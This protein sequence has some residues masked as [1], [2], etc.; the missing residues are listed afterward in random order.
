MPVDAAI[1][2]SQSSM[3]VRSAPIRGLGA[4]GQRSSVV[5]PVAET[6]INVSLTRSDNETSDALANE[7][8]AGTAAT[9]GSLPMTIER[10]ERCRGGMVC[11]APVVA[12]SERW[13]RR[14]DRRHGIVD[15][16]NCRT[17]G[18]GERRA[19]AG[20]C[21][22]MR[23]A[24]DELHGR[25]R[26]S[27]ASARESAGCERW[28]LCAARVMLPSSTIARK[29]RRW[30]SST[31]IRHEHQRIS[32]DLRVVVVFGLV[33]AAMNVCFYVAVA[34]L[35]LGIAVTIELFGPLGLAAA[36]SRTAREWGYVALAVV[37]VVLL[38][39]ATHHLDRIGVAY[40]LAAA[41]GWASYILLSRRTGRSF[42]GVDGLALTMV[43]ATVA[44]APFGIATG[45]ARLIQT[46]SARDRIR[47]GDAVGS[48]PVQP[49]AP[50][51]ARCRATYVRC[52]HDQQPG[53]RRGYGL[54]CA[55]RVAR[56]TASDG[57]C[58]RNSR[59]RRHGSG[60][61]CQHLGRVRCPLLDYDLGVRVRK[62]EAHDVARR[63]TV[64]QCRHR[65]E[66]AAELDR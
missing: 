61:R 42:D 44:V 24:I 39:G 51:T 27:R 22:V 12:K 16:S 41:I 66:V 3:F 26:S 33:L 64:G 43:V 5:V 40:A 23:R 65:S 52:R 60:H 32:I 28:R 36:L 38:G 49:R 47:S 54:G 25:P 18:F 15:L 6:T 20:Q 4:A 10:N 11:T 63:W 37:G 9:R 30:R 7:W 55:R 19:G 1:A 34:R 58:L 62:P 50:R 13:H 57:D 45:G 48:D 21:H 17:S 35:P 46:R 29:Q 2:I 31:V 8:L 59:Q 56:P 14:A 53:D